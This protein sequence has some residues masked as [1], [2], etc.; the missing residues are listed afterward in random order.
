[1]FPLPGWNPLERGVY[2]GWKYHGR[3]WFGHQSLWPAASLFVR[4]HP[5]RAL[6]LVV[7]SRRHSAAVVAARVFGAQLPELFDLRIPVGRSA[8]PPCGDGV[9]FASAAWHAEIRGRELC[10]RRRGSRTI[11][12][13]T[14]SHV[15][16]GVSLARPVIESFPHVEVVARGA[17]A[18]LWNGRFVLPDGD[19]ASPG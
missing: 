1:V 8:S 7:A 9:A 11:H 19:A 2:L 10:V 18:Y 6:A 3:G 13:A 12:R 15:G 5:R 17:S 16:G 4:A 14:L